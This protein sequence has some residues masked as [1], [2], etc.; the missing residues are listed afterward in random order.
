MAERNKHGDGTRAVVTFFNA[1]RRLA[2]V[3]KSAT[4]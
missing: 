3:S 1:T 2:E 4:S